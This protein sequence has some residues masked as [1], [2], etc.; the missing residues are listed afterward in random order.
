MKSENIWARVVKKPQSRVRRSGQFQRREVEVRRQSLG[1]F[2]RVSRLHQGRLGL[3]GAWLSHLF[4]K[5]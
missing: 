1:R 4:K 5:Y 2:L 3:W